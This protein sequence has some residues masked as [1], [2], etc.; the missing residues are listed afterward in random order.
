[1]IPCW[2]I[3]PHLFLPPF[4]LP[5]VSTTT[6]A[7]QA[8]P[9]PGSS[10]PPSTCSGKQPLH[11]LCH[12]IPHTFQLALKAHPSFTNLISLWGHTLLS[13]CKDPAEAWNANPRKPFLPALL[14]GYSSCSPRNLDQT[15]GPNLTKG[16]VWLRAPLHCRLPGKELPCGITTPSWP[17]SHSRVSVW[18]PP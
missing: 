11:P 1:M 13:S 15:S 14:S 6:S 18:L 12:S 17:G 2:E 8:L 4:L 7:P 3:W 10:W 9:F 16:Q 5:V